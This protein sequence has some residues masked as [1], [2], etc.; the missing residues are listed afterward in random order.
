MFSSLPCHN[1]TWIQ[2][3]AVA[4][5][6]VGC[7][8]LTQ[9]WSQPSHIKCIPII[10]RIILMEK[11]KRNGTS[12]ST[13]LFHG[14]TLPTSMAYFN[15][16]LHKRILM[17]QWLCGP[18]IKAFM[19]LPMLLSLCTVMWLSGCDL[20]GETGTLVEVSMCILVIQW[21]NRLKRSILV[22]LNQCYKGK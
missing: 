19:W 9:L 5:F 8:F 22:W 4:G 3:P 6:S 11:M 14:L 16:E 7:F 18:G 20:Q 21:N 10:V 15:M 17:V 1:N 12:H 2:Y 13:S